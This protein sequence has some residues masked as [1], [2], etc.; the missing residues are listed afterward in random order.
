MFY[1]LSLPFGFLPGRTLSGENHD[2]LLFF[3]YPLL[4]YICPNHMEPY[5]LHYPND[6]ALTFQGVSGFYFLVYPFQDVNFSISAS[7]ISSPVCCSIQTHC[8]FGLIS[9]NT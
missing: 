1:S 2:G 8:P 7:E 5:T 3:Q 9:R 4:A 6:K